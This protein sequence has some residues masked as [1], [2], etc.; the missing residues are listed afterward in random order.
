M[1]RQRLWKGGGGDYFI[2]VTLIIVIVITYLL[3][4][5]CSFWKQ[6]KQKIEIYIM[7]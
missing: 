1:D 4:S 6:Q 2:L 7:I 5:I 3:T